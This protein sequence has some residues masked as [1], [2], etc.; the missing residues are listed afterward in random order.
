MRQSFNGQARP[1]L[2]CGFVMAMFLASSQGLNALS[3]SVQK[4]RAPT[5]ADTALLA[6]DYAKAEELYKAELAKQAGDA[7]S[8]LGLIHAL[9]RE[10]KVDE[11]AEAVKSAMQ[12][13][14]NSAALVTARGEVE[15]RKGELWLVEATVREAA[16]IDPCNART[17]L[18]FAK[19]LEASSRYATAKQQTV[20]AHQFDPA[21][22]EIT[23]AWIRTLPLAQRVTEMDGLLAGP[24]GN[25]Q[26]T[27]GYLK[28][29]LARWK[30][31]AAGPVHECKLVA[32]SAP[33]EIEM[34]RLSRGPYAPPVP[35]ME[36]TL[37]GISVR[38]SIDTRNAGITLFRPGANMAKVTRVGTATQM[39]FMGKQ[40]YMAVA[41]SVKIGGLEFKDCAVTVVEADSPSDDGV[42]MIGMDIFSNY[43]VTVDFPMRKVGLAPLPARPGAGAETAALE[44]F[45]GDYDPLASSASQFDRL[46]PAELKDY[47]QIYRIGHDLLLPTAI[48]GEKAGAP[49]VENIKLF[50]PDEG[51]PVTNIERKA[52]EEVTKVYEDTHQEFG[53]QKVFVANQV[54]FN[55]VKLAQKINGVPIADTGLVSAIDGTEIG[56][57]IGSLTLTQFTLHIDYRDGLMKA[58]YIPGRGFKFAVDSSHM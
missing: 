24:N 32:G 14:P 21:D 15:F 5:D 40:T 43:L 12:K 47:S 17:R 37:N 46:L 16:K 22:P 48:S 30:E 7:D 41:D 28:N 2:A 10:Q 35:G 9:L 26:M 29:E 19:L 23:L 8:Q 33:A 42:G 50:V 27:A 52:A 3:C 57:S 25:D 51:A 38:L 6:G 36:A 58:E 13:T 4:H 53:N 34:V 1:I 49:G 45:A 54:G 11:A 56:G 55:F 20:L 31:E 44:T 18:L 39:G